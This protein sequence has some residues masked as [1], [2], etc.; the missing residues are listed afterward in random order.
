LHSYKKIIAS[1]DEWTIKTLNPICRLF[2]KTDLLTDFAALCLTDF[3]GWI[4]IH[5][6]LVFSTQL[7]NCCPHGRRNYTCVLLP[8]Y[9]LF[10]PPHPTICTVYTDSVTVGGWWGVVG[11]VLNCAV[12]HILQ[13]FYSL[14]LTRFR[15]Y[16]IASPP[17]KKITSK[18][19]IKGLVSL[20]FLRPWL[21]VLRTGD[22]GEGYGEGRGKYDDA[23]FIAALCC[24]LFS[25]PRNSLEWHS[26]GLLLFLFHGMEVRVVFSSAEWF[27][28]EFREVIDPRNGIPSC[29]LFRGMVRNGISKV[30]FY[31]WSTE[32]NSQLFSL[33]RKGSKR[34]SESFL[35]SRTVGIP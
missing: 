27:G 13:E 2:F 29:F 4:C 33:P 17:K 31:F 5:S 11:V 7:V 6:W 20:K 22:G 26:E 24:E 23:L 12:D 30:C 9:L 21:Q 15:T 10:D 19:N 25:L 1:M 28:T 3:I 34:N 8:L 32:R 14:F 16:K 18:Y 35:F